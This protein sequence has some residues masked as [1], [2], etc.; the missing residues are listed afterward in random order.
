MRTW[1]CWTRHFL[2][3]VLAV[4][5]AAS[6]QPTTGTRR[7]R[8]RDT[9]A[10][11]VPSASVR[12]IE[13]AANQAIESVTDADGDFAFPLLRPGTYVVVTRADGFRETRASAHVTVA[14][15]TAVELRLQPAGIAEVVTVTAVPRWPP[16]RQARARRARAWAGG[17]AHGRGALLIRGHMNV[18]TL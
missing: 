15:V 9:S 6:A 14:G 8:V 1:Q 18:L 12:V 4:I 13:P 10:V 7:G 17:V 16:R 5:R 11:S 2:A 3:G